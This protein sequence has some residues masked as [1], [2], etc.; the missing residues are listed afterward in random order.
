MQNHH[1]ATWKPIFEQ[2]SYYMN[3]PSIYQLEYM[4]SSTEIDTIK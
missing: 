2:L 3:K 4:G 1:F